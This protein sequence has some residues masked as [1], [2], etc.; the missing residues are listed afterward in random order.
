MKKLFSF[1]G[2]KPEERRRLGPHFS[3][4][5]STRLKN[6]NPFYKKQVGYLTQCDAG[7]G[8][9]VAQKLQ[10]MGAA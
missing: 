3:L 9:R 10:S 1:P 6:K 5:S 4:F 7:L 2:K 8:R